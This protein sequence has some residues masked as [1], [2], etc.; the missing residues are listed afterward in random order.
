LQA[1]VELAEL[2]LGLAR[3]R[4]RVGEAAQTEF[5][6]SAAG[7]ATARSLAGVPPGAGGNLVALFKVLGGDVQQARGRQNP[8][9]RP[10]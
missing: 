5:W 4:F 7:R 9:S 10:G 2:Q 1:N 3:Q 6:R 8:G